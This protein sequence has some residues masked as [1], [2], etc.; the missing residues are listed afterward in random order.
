MLLKPDQLQFKD[1]KGF[2][3][4]EGV[5][6]CGKS[7]LQKKLAKEILS[8]GFSTL[9]TREPGGTKMG[10][11]LREILQE[12]R[13]GKISDVAELLLFAADRAQ[14]IEEV[15]KPALQNHQLVIS[16]RYF[17][18]TTAFQGYGRGLDQTLV[19]KINGVAVRDC[20]PDV[21]L[22]LDLDPEAG[23]RRNAKDSNSLSSKDTFESEDMAFH[24]RIRQGFLE[25]AKCEVTPFVQI[26]ASKSKDDVFNDAMMAVEKLLVQFKK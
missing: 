15:I 5:N 12:G 23:L 3:V 21:V 8:L 17:Y 20:L 24:R 7:T 4:L 14:H 25:I 19:Q 26:D 16:D 10:N 22:L 9:C 2:I 6:G 11:E 1:P 13:V 18:S